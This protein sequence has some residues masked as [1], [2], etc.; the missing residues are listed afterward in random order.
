MSVVHTI[1]G[2]EV[3]STHGHL[4]G[5]TRIKVRKEGGVWRHVPTGEHVAAQWDS[6][7][8]WTDGV[9]SIVIVTS[10]FDNPS[11]APFLPDAG[12]CERI[13]MSVM[14]EEADAMPAMLSIVPGEVWD[15][16][17][18]E[19]QR[20]IGSVAIALILAEGVTAAAPKGGQWVG[21]A[22]GRVALGELRHHVTEAGLSNRWPMC[23]SFLSDEEREGLRKK[24]T[25]GDK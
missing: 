20:R 16:L 8:E 18:T 9:P 21:E 25:Q 6:H 1:R 10:E 4:G 2:R 13:G 5:T 7:G 24:S 15:E 3:L 22:L 14:R 23:W 19:T 17:P 12:E 11:R